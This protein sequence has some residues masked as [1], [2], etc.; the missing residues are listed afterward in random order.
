MQARTP[1]ILVVDDDRR[2][3]DTTLATIR[4]HCASYEARIA[5]GVFEGLD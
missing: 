5:M 2:D 4:T 3:L 1:R